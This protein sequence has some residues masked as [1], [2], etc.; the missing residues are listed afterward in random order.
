MSL[1]AWFR[2][3]NKK[4]MAFVVIALMIVFTIQPVMDYLSGRRSAGS[5]AIAY[6]GDNKKITGEDR[7]MAQQQL[8]ILKNL[9]ADYFLRP[10]DPRYTQL[11]D[12]R[13]DL[14][15]ELLF[16]EKSTAAETIGWIRQTVAR[17]DYGITDKQI[18]DMYDRKYAPDMYWLMLTSEAKQAGVQIPV[19]LARAQ[20][21][22]MIPQLH[23]GAT[24]AQFINAVVARG[25]VT[26]EQV[27]ETF[28]DL[29][30]V[31]EY[32]KMACSM[33]NRTAQQELTETAFRL[34]KMD[35]EY[36]LFDTSESAGQTGKPAEEKIVEQFT[37]YKGFFDGDVNE[38]NP[39][40][41]GYKLPDR[42][43]IEYIAVRLDDVAATIPLP[44]DQEKEEY[45]AQ[46]KSQSPIAYMALSDPNDPNS[47]QIV[48]TRSYAEVASAISKGLYRQ[49]VDSKTEQI[50]SDARSITEANM[51]EVENEANRPSDE[52]LKKQA[53]DYQKTAAELSDKYKLKVYEGKTGLLSAAEIQRDAQLG[54]LYLGGAGSANVGLVRVLFAVEQ[55]KA[56]V[57][58]P[59]DAKIPRFYENI[60]PLKDA[61]EPTQGYSGNNMML[62]RIVKTAKAV[63]PQSVDE[64]LNKQTVRFDQQASVDKD[65]NSVREQVVDDLKR[66]SA[67]D[68]VKDTVGQ[69]AK[70][71][72]KDGWDEA[73]K[74][75]N[76][77]HDDSNSLKP[78]L[79]LQTR[80]GLER[81]P[82]SMVAVAAI[83]Y[84]GDPLGREMLARVKAEKILTEDFYSLM[85]PDS[86]ALAAAA[87][88][89]EYK[90]GM[91]YYCLKSLVIHRLFQGQ[92]DRQKAREMVRDDFTDGQVLA[93]THYNPENILKR[94]NFTIVQEQ[95]EKTASEEP[96]KPAPPVDK[97]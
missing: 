32:G 9:G 15:G 24:Y 42:V 87:T 86:N 84:Q 1:M 92:F 16:A 57:L 2:K 6:Y 64:K 30:T 12:L 82:A 65:S 71:V 80:K 90:P 66:F 83:R 75:Y 93:M 3:N 48:K 72:E 95:Q 36:V 53:V 4:L 88:I 27:L 85:P 26:E 97:I 54:T 33:Q 19:E 70:A 78:G 49:K 37:K 74:K 41:F 17:G 52:Q 91:N 59:L 38:D 58:G 21:E 43:Q 31:I 44:T 7:T 56:S 14:L 18:N 20:L 68:K 61:R 79:T 55:L 96:N 67:M 13:T 77:A 63:E 34:E 11:Q 89:V 10:Q 25:N 45:Y 46:H 28:A 51:P 62:V 50:L 40:G 35:V 39:Y 5:R 23:K 81:I 94:M 29:L 60:G 47:Q 69:F 76:K 8:E 22:K 73:I